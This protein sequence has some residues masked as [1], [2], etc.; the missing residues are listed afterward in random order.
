MGMSV[1][2]LGL[3]LAALLEQ[4]RTQVEAM[5]PAPATSSTDEPRV[6]GAGAAA[7]GS[8]RAAMASDGRLVELSLDDRTSSMP[9]HELE[10]EV[11][12]AVNAA[13]ASLHGADE[14]EA[15][16]A[17]I[18]PAVLN[19]QLAAVQEQGLRSMSR[20]TSGLLDAMRQIERNTRS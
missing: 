2:R 5:R 3:D 1:D 20:I 8:I 4:A 9:R 15:A 11:M 16:A 12:A 7:D 6:G 17:S 14:A 19:E 10:R 18:D 13:W